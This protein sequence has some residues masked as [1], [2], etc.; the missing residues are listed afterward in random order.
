[1]GTKI[2]LGATT[3]SFNDEYHSYELSLE[4]MFATIGSLGPKQGLEII[5]PQCIRTYPEVSEEF[6]H[7]FRDAVERYDLVPSA[8]GHYSDLGRIP[9]RNLSIAE[10]VEFSRIQLEGAK[11][12]GY[13]LA[14][15]SY[16]SFDLT[17]RREALYRQ[18]LPDLERLDMKLAIEIHAPHIIESEPQQRVIE[19]VAALNSPYVGF[20]LDCGCMTNRVSPVCERKFLELGVDPAIVKRLIDFWATAPSRA[21]L[22]WEVAAIGGGSLVELLATETWIYFGHGKP[23]ALREIMPYVFHVH[24]K[25]FQVDENGNDDAVAYPQIIEILVSSGYDGWI[26]SEYEGHHWLKNRNAYAQVKA[27]QQYLR[28]LIAECEASGS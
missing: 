1:M 12:L 20:T 13:R 18:L 3:Y 25:F 11:R 28:R 22:N 4:R 6:E 27:H 17:D 2:R 21:E 23:A 14:R 7:I 5:A 26:S 15:M 16:Q 24:G 8:F 19:D 9:G 10:A